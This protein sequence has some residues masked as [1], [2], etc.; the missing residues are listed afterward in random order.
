MPGFAR[1]LADLDPWEASYTRS[2]ARRAR[3]GGASRTRRGAHTASSSLSELI[4]VR[5]RVARD[6][7]EIEPWELSLGRS[8]ARRRAAQLRF[9]PASTRAKRVSLGAL[10][11]LTAGPAAASLAEGGGGATAAAAG[12]GTPP[13]QPPATAEHTITL[14]TGSG[15]RQV[16]LLQHELG[17]IKVDGVYGPETEAAVEAFQRSRGLTVDNV[18]GPQTGAALGSHAATTASLASFHGEMPGEGARTGSTGGGSTGS[19]STSG[20]TMDAV[21][22]TGLPTGSGT[23][24]GAG[25]TP[26]EGNPAM[27]A[28]G[29][30]A[31]HSEGEG[32]AGTGAIRRLQGALHLHVDGEFGPETEAAILRLQARKG[33][34]V[35]GVAGPATW[36]TVGVK[37]ET[38][39]TP[40]ESALPQPPQSAEGEGA[41][42][43]ASETGGTAAGAP[44]EGDGAA[45]PAVAV[46]TG[47][48]S[49]DS[50]EAP[51]PV[52]TETETPHVVHSSGGEESSSSSGS[53]STGGGEGSGAVSRVIAAGNEI[54]RRPYVYGGGHGSFQSGGYDCSGSVS[55][56]L[57]GGGL[58]NSPQDSTG[59]ESYGSSGPGRHITI[60]TNSEHAFMV[61][62]GKRF[63]TVAQQEGGSRWSSSMTSTSGYVVRHPPG[64]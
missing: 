11:A 32:E 47:G 8:R 18:V 22:T 28:G 57:H 61:V 38:T 3:A 4:D 59:L 54:A 27:V 33:L 12:S 6:L 58:L 10:A 25:P 62:N 44:S 30:E 5:R 23:A 39:L 37:H 35:D 26:T 29:A 45:R 53:S 34:N 19:G 43:G 46:A 51:R 41:Q 17:G 31:G 36:H 64:Q 49:S 50:G 48:A 1:D 52:S 7:A 2:R 15:G 63:D 16:A 24:T 21:Y 14:T 40:P 9:V 42:G 13:P 55:Y 60:Y 56:A 20:S